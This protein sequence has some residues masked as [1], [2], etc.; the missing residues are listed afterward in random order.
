MLIHHADSAVIDYDTGTTSRSGYVTTTID[1]AHQDIIITID[2]D[3]R[4]A[5]HGAF[6]AAAKSCA[7][8]GNAQKAVVGKV[9]FVAGNVTVKNPEDG[10]S[11]AAEGEII[12]AQNAT[13][14]DGVIY[15]N[16]KVYTVTS[17]P[18]LAVSIVEFILIIAAAVCIVVLIKKSASKAQKNK[19]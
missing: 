13:L 5:E 6:V 4:V 18:W 12:G 9:K 7:I 15:S 10:V 8:A 14:Q 19:K 2:S 16:Q 11:K 3:R 1:V 17:G